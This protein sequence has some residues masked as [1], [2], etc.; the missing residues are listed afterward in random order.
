[1][2]SVD[3]DRFVLEGVVTDSCKGIFTVELDGVN[4]VVKTRLSGKIRQNDIKVVIGDRVKVEL[5]KEDTTQG[6]IIFR[7]RL[8]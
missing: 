8:R 3:R 6:R 1:M 5:S 4:T 7:E 2:D